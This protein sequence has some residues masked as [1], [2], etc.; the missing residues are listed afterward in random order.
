MEFKFTE[1]EAIALAAIEV[2][3]GGVISAGPE[4]GDRLGEVLR[5]ELLNVDRRKVMALVSEGLGSV[6]SQDEIE[7]LVADF[8]VQLQQKV[9]EKMIQ[10]SSA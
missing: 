9:S 6:L 4:L 5:L 10:R 7:T 3:A 1:A 2:E 8:Q